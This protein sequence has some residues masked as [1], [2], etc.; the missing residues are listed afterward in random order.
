MEYIHSVVVYEK[1]LTRLG[2]ILIFSP[3]LE[4]YQFSQHCKIFLIYDDTIY[5]ISKSIKID[6]VRELKVLV[7]NFIVIID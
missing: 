7:D 3:R 2:E 4:N 6:F 1:Y 5:L